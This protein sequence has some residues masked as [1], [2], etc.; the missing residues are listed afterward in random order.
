MRFTACPHTFA[1]LFSFVRHGALSMGS[2]S[3]RQEG[4]TNEGNEQS[5]RVQRFDGGVCR[6]NAA[7]GGA[8]YRAMR[9]HLFH[10]DSRV[11]PDGKWRIHP[12]HLQPRD[13]GRVFWPHLLVGLALAGAADCGVGSAS[14]RRKNCSQAASCQS[15]GAFAKARGNHARDG[16]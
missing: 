9:G 11:K 10:R 8:A 5:A 14:A 13:R 12:S 3:K 7:C 16:A 4:I 1:Y 2:I 6:C 15:A